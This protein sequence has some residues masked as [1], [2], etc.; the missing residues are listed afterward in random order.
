MGTQ[1]AV[2]SAKGGSQPIDIS[3]DNQNDAYSPI[4]ASTASIRLI[5][6]SNQNYSEILSGDYGDYEVILRYEDANTPGTYIDYWCG[7][8]V[9]E[10]YSEHVTS[11]P[12]N[13]TFK[14]TD[15]LGLLSRDV[16]GDVT[17]E[18]SVSLLS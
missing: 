12:Y 5:V 1:E 4:V 15:G 14:A 16:V 9:R 3:W 11:F 8:V 2:L 10:S 17:S 18:G 6:D 13:V 7:L